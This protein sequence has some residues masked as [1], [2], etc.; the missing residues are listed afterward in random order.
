MA[1]AIAYRPKNTEDECTGIAGMTSA[2]SLRQ[3]IT[4][5]GWAL[6]GRN[7]SAIAFRQTIAEDGCVW[8]AVISSAI[9][10]KQLT[11]DDE[12]A[13]TGGISS[14]IAWKSLSVADVQVEVGEKVPWL[15]R[16]S[17]FSSRSTIDI[18]RH[19]MVL[20]LNL[21]FF[22]NRLGHWFSKWFCN[23]WKCNKRCLLHFRI[24]TS[25]RTV[26][27]IPAQ[28]SRRNSP[29]PRQILLFTVSKKYYYNKIVLQC[30]NRAY[31][32]E[33]HIAMH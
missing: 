9:A 21:I 14:A 28:V 11:N 19:E 30:V 5:D 33:S 18:Y 15:G 13:W 7:R 31:L 20:F 22:K 4:D 1:S 6:I 8:T 23:F 25:Q 24:Y 17:I 32:F 12:C 16:S 26:L 2:I 3:T 29:V 27:D 10:Q